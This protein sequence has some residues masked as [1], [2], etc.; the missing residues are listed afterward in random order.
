MDHG[1]YMWI[2]T[3]FA[4]VVSEGVD[5]DRISSALEIV[6]GLFDKVYEKTPVRS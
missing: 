1:K 5:N 2:V 4:A 6:I 3:P